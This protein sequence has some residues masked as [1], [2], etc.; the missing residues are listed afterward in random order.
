[1]N[2]SI[3]LFTEDALAEGAAIE[4]TPAQAHYLGTVMRRAPGETVAL[5]N[6]RDGEW[7][8]RIEALRR[9][10]G[11]FVAEARLRAQDEDVPLTL[12]F[13]LLK[14][15]ATDLVVQKA[16]ELGATAILPVLTERTNAARVNRDRLQAIARE[17]AEQCERL[18]VPEIAAPVPVLE[19]VGAWTEG[20]LY[21]AAERRDAPFLPPAGGA[22]AGLLVGPEGGFAARELDA[23]LSRPLVKAVSLGSRILRAETAAI[24]GLGLLQA[25][26]SR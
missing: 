25:P 24:V 18:G 12:L 1:M 11:R 21:V 26:R 9:D 5:F 20:P 8:A 2:G 17:A 7:R 19:A 14:R 22:A 23:L 13:A 10:R 16:T 3:R 4:A 15:D 6:G